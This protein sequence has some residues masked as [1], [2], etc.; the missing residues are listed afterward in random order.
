[1]VYH[2]ITSKLFLWLGGPLFGKLERIS[3]IN[4]TST[5]T[6]RHMNQWAV[7]LNEKHWLTY[8]ESEIEI[9]KECRK[10]HHHVDF[11]DTENLKKQK[12]K[13]KK[14]RWR[15]ASNRF[16]QA[17]QQLFSMRPLTAAAT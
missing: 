6:Q 10:R 7:F 16:K 11:K 14:T 12:K 2:P 8:M 15:V 5:L 13:Q 3:T 17:L 9:M 1:M 4:L